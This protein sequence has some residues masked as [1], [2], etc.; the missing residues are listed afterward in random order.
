MK[1]L[2]FAILVIS[3]AVVS[4]RSDDDSVQ[5]IDQVV[6]LYIDSAGTDMLNSKIKNTYQSV[7]MNDVNGFTDTAPVTSTQTFGKDS[8]Y[9]LEY[10]SGARKILVDS[11]VVDAK[12][13]QSKIALI[14]TKKNQDSTLSTFSDTLKL[15]YLSK[16]DI[17]KIDKIW[18]NN[19]PVSFE[20]V[21]DANLIK[22]VK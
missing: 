19:K 6:H 4:C 21:A 22:I 12:I 3:A 1:N 16:P 20:K 2:F 10:V 17:F 13:Y 11:S 5:K 9:Y 7:K 15:N 18:Y 14:F 8:I